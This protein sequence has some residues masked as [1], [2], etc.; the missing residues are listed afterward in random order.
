MDDKDLEC[1]QMDRKTETAML[2]TEEYLC[3]FVIMREDRDKKQQLLNDSMALAE[4]RKQENER[5]IEEHEEAEK[6]RMSG[7]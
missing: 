7:K 5:I 3:H 4:E 2:Q 1:V 6:R